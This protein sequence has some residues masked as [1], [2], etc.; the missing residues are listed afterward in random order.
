MG[1][2]IYSRY[3]R[4]LT[5][6]EFPTRCPWFGKFMRG[7]KLRMGVMKKQDFEIPRK[8]V[9]SMIERREE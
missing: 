1:A 6:T 7:S 5:A 3:E 2:T 9:T 8:V 4:I